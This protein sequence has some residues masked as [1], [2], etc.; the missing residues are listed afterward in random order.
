MT[1]QFAL[2]PKDAKVQALAKRWLHMVQETTGGDAAIE[3]SAR[4][5]PG[6]LP[7]RPTWKINSA[8]RY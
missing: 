7:I 6:G 2:R 5:P 4:L 1:P 8:A 3:Q